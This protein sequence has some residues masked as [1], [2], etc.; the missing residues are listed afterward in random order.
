MADQL[1]RSVGDMYTGAMI[2]GLVL[3]G[4]YIAYILLMYLLA[5]R[6]HAGP[7]A[8]GAHARA[9]RDLADRLHSSLAIIIAMAVHAAL[10]AVSKA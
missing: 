4:L 2:P 8:G 6:F 10:I 7:A 5:P 3:T 9:R 1:G